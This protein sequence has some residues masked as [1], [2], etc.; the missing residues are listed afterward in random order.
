[1]RIGTLAQATGVNVE[2]IRY[3][4][5]IGLLAK[6]A[7]RPN[8]YRAYGPKH[9]ERLLFIRHCRAL[10]MPLALVR[11][12]S[13]FMDRPQADCGDINDLIDQ[14]LEQVRLQLR[15]MRTLEKQLTRLRS[16]CGTGI[17]VASCGILRL[18]ALPTQ[19]EASAPILGD[20]NAEVR[21]SDK[22]T[23]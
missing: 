16:R 23:T 12:I 11:R 6:P 10:D 13:N 8:G 9:L 19:G 14:Q 3:Y 22:K 15:S 21:L 2:T 7:R 1:M 4:E 5:R 20:S 18:L 17:R